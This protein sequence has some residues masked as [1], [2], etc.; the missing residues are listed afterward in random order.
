MNTT[1]YS[2]LHRVDTASVSMKYTDIPPASL[3]SSPLHTEKEMAAHL[4]ISM[5]HLCNLR[6]TG[7]PFIQ[8]G[9]SIRYDM[10]EV[11]AYLKTNRRLSS[12]VQRQQRRASIAAQGA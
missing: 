8:L 2:Q 4:K 1:D 6:K 5:R 10:S 12:H 11:L 3:V 9:S 7:M